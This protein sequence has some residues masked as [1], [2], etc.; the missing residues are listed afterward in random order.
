ML[1]FFILPT[2]PIQQDELQQR[3]VIVTV[4][5]ADGNPVPG[6][7]MELAIRKPLTRVQCTTDE[8]GRCEMTVGTNE[9]LVNGTILIIG[10]GRHTVLFKGDSVEIDI[11]LTESGVI[12]LPQD[13]HSHV[14]PTATPD[15]E[16]TADD[17]A[18]SVIE[19][20]ADDPIEATIE[21]TADDPADDTAD[22]VDT[23]IETPADDPAEV[24]SETETTTTATETSS[25]TPI[26]VYFIWLIVIL[27]IAGL[28][29]LGWYYQQGG[30]FF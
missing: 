27:I 7:S 28:G 18:E 15:T 21:V 19:A 2:Q 24:G 8:N 23:P 12:D 17:P 26:W 1:I 11:Q 5:D 13:L 20:T 10:S 14:E 25:S 3:T 6:K 22:T 16:S 30:R 29:L 9:V 4:I